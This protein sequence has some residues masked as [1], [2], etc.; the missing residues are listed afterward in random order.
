[1][2]SSRR[3]NGY[4]VQTKTKTKIQVNPHPMTVSEVSILLRTAS[5][6]SCSFC[7]VNANETLADASSS[8]TA[9]AHPRAAVAVAGTDKISGTTE[10]GS[11]LWPTDEAFA[12][13]RFRLRYPFSTGAHQVDETFR[14]HSRPDASLTGCSHQSP[15][16]PPLSSFSNGTIK[17]MPDHQD[18]AAATA[19]NFEV[20]LCIANDITLFEKKT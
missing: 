16:T 19:L 17:L 8:T 9:A 12:S 11:V 6:V 4:N 2:S 18:D 1:V 3:L 14:C 20:G 10:N 13:R 7:D 15:S 5:S